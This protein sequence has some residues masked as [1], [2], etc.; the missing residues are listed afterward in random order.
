M[1]KHSET[2]KPSNSTKPLLCDGLMTEDLI[3][4]MN[5]KHLIML[6]DFAYKLAKKAGVKKVEKL[7]E[8]DLLINSR[9]YE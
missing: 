2:T 7:K 3:I 4:K 1:T 5:K 8:I 6:Y 9:S